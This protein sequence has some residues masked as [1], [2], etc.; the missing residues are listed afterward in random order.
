M[1]WIAMDADGGILVMWNRRVVERLEDMVGSYS[2]F[3]RWKGVKD[4][5]VWACLGCID[6]TMIAREVCFGMS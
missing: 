2:D 4:G 1:D 3:I 6:R 5:F